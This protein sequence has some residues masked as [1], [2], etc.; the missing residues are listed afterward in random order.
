MTSYTDLVAI[1]DQLIADTHSITYSNY[2]IVPT[3]FV[4]ISKDYAVQYGKTKRYKI[5]RR[6]N[7]GRLF[8]GN[9]K[10]ITRH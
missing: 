8:I 6:G 10:V 3:T 2:G 9:F 5:N 4:V 1:G 7:D